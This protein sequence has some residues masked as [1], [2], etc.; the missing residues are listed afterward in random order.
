MTNQLEKIE[1]AARALAEAE[2]LDEIKY[3]RDI[4]S[5]AAEYA[6]AAK[7]GLEAQNS[8]ATIKLRAERKAGELLAGLERGQGGHTRFGSSSD[9]QTE[10]PY[11]A[12][13]A[14]TDTTRQQA[15][16]W[17]T[18]ARL[19]EE[20]FE[21]Y[22]EETIEAGNEVTTAGALRIAQNVHVANN[23]GNNEWY[24]PP[25]YIAAAR[26]VMGGIDTDPASSAV[27]NQTVKAGVYFDE[28]YDGLRREW[29]GRVWLNPPY[30]QPEIG[31]FCAKL[32]AEIEGGRVRQAITLTNNATETAWFRVLA[33]RCTAV[34]FPSSR[35]RF[36]DAQGRAN[37]T[38]LQGQALMYFGDRTAVFAREFAR[39]GLVFY[40]R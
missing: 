21:A 14:D 12:T 39:F 40:A 23:S 16:R 7:L 10:S 36:L 20:K 4:A 31:D 5:A 15:N 8:A 1:G 11:A 29:H 34:C 24:T 33:E 3:V 17:Q 28:D 27:A 26:A 18:V 6:R 37:G 2:T 13:L 30:S 19:P 25:E 32:V 9:G 35:I 38:P 22:I